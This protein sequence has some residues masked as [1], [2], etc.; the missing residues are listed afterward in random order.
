MYIRTPADYSE[1]ISFHF[2]CKFI[3][4]YLTILLA[5]LETLKLRTF[6]AAAT[7]TAC[8]STHV[9]VKVS[10]LYFLTFA[11]MKER[12]KSLK[13]TISLESAIDKGT[14]KTVKVPLGN[15]SIEQ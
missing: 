14:S 11:G 15:S 3:L 5:A 6:S 9:T 4:Q 12:I 13:G 10:K 1:G 8:S 2:F 7:Q